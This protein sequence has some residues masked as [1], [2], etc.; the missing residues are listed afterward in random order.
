M[1]R[2]RYALSV[3]VMLI[4]SLLV[5]AGA[6]AQVTVS[7]V[8][9]DPTAGVNFTV[10]FSDQTS[11]PIENLLLLEFGTAAPHHLFFSVNDGTPSS[12]VGCPVTNQAAFD[13]I[14]EIRVLL[15]GGVDALAFNAQALAFNI[16][17]QPG[18][19]NPPGDQ[20]VQSMTVSALTHSLNLLVKGA[21]TIQVLGSDDDDGLEVEFDGGDRVA[22][23]SGAPNGFDVI[24]SSY[25][26]PI[27]FVSINR[28]RLVG[29]EG[30]TSLEATFAPRNLGGANLYETTLGENDVLA[31]EGSGRADSFAVNL[32][33]GSTPT[34]RVVLNGVL[35]TNVG[36][37]LQNLTIEAR[38]AADAIAV[39]VGNA[40]GPR[41]LVEGG[42]PSSQSGDVLRVRSLSPRARFT[43]QRIGP[44]AGTVVVRYPNRS[45]RVD[46][47]GTERVRF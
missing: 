2:A 17:F 41:V 1:R 12:S 5:G 15:E 34:T 6:E 10:T 8:D 21:E 47:E 40:S 27:L 22:R 32:P 4:G 24:Q 26:P 13:Q 42:R 29:D 28:F 18:G 19:P 35:I 9:N 44:N 38:G 7:C 31:V 36:P 23:V 45:L 11:F 43:T 37:T 3:V 16:N 20:D 25:A 39:N 33:T 30:G 46:F 14:G